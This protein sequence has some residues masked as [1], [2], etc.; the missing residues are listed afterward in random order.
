VKNPISDSRD[1]A[2]RQLS[3]PG[4]LARFGFHAPPAIAAARWARQTP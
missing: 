3:P 1:G 2:A 4:A